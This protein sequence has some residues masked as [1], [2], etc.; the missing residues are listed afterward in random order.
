MHAL[1]EAD[2]LTKKFGKVQ[3]LADLTLTLPPG[4]PVAILGPNGA[5]KTTFIRMV[6]TLHRAR[7]RHARRQRARRRARP[8]G[9]APHDRPRR[10]V[11]RR[12]G[13]DDR[14]ARTWSWWP[15][16]TARAGRGGQRQRRAH[17]RADGSGGGRR[18][19]GPD[20]FRRH[21]PAARPRGEP[22]RL[23]PAAPARRADDGPRPR[24]PQ[25]G[26][27]R[28]P[29]H[30]LGRD[31]HRAHHPVSRRGRPPR[32]RTS[33]SSTAAASSPRAR[34]TSSSPGSAPTWSSCTRSTSRPCSGPPRCSASLGMAE[35]STDP[36]T[37]RCS[38][39]A[40]GGSKLLPDRRARARRRRGPGGGHRAAPAHPRRG[41]PRPHRAHHDRPAPLRR[42]TQ[43]DHG[44]DPRPA[45]P[46]AR[47]S[48]AVTNR[49]A[50]YLVASSQV[51][52]RTLKK[53]VRTPALHHRRHRAGR[54]LPAHLPL[55]L[56]RRGGATPGA[57][58]Y[59]DFLVPGFVV[60][61]VLF[62]G[63]G[64]ASGVADDQEGGL[65]D[66]LRSLP[67]RL[68]SI[69]TGRVGADSALVAWG[70]LVM[71]A[72]GFA[73]GFRLG[74]TTARRGGGAR[75]DH[76]LRLRLRLDVH[77][78]GPRGRQPAGGPGAVVPGLPAQL[79]LVG[80]RAGVD[81]AGLD[82]GLRQQPAHDADGQH[83]AAADRRSGGAGSCSGTPS[84]TTWCPRCCGRP[85]SSWCSRRWPSWKL[86]T[87]VT[88]A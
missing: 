10:P 43:H 3:A 33:S 37:R 74:G 49:G 58:S 73:V 32:R 69:I 44:P 88:P 22:G 87:V 83:G 16:S 15:A 41:V 76:P 18:P 13:D 65:F 5:G 30:E 6:A 71:T 40:P 36:A 38:L 1:I 86:K 66:R 23:A 75:P 77:R 2:G 70:V 81:H 52:A 60:T 35:P 12:R 24:Q 82:A 27:G 42:R 53:F 54:A 45:A 31:R 14:A 57:S 50:S 4:E 80:L 84:R 64:A 72:V 51:A 34:R 79:R 21:A 29:R 85:G 62:Q 67:I 61:G 56:R 7:P 25:R 78:H 39:A 26:V 20:L 19:P 68:L 28:H 8:D 59:V 48:T 9:G 11:R 46:G 47:R 55:R 63:M 17:P